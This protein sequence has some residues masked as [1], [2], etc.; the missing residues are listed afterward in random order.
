[1]MVI[2]RL[3]RAPLARVRPAG[4]A[5]F[6]SWL[7]LRRATIFH[8]NCFSLLLFRAS[9]IAQIGALSS[10]VFAPPEAGR[11]FEWLLPM[12][13]MVV[14]L[15]LVEGWQAYA[16][17]LEVVLRRPLPVRVAVYALVIS[18]IVLLGEQGEIPFVYFQF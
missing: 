11:A 4:R 2:H 17:D 1:M 10:L 7:W 8:L 12:A 18:G 3:A 5:G 14:P 15:L 16:G 13:V 9:T 6:L